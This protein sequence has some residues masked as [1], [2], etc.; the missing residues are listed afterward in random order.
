MGNLINRTVDDFK[1]QAY[2]QGRFREITRGF[3]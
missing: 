1:V 3:T 2:D